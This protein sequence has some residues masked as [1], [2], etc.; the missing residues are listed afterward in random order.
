MN[1][2]YKE[3]LKAKVVLTLTQL[4]RRGFNPAIGLPCTTQFSD[5]NCRFSAFKV[6]IYV[7]DSPIATRN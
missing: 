1:K 7:A 3:E 4:E 6:I 5:S 2:N